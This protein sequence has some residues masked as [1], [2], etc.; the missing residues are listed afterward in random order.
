[1]LRIL[2]DVYGLAPATAAVDTSTAFNLTRAI[3]V[4]K[5]AVL[6]AVSEARGQALF[7]GTQLTA[8]T[9]LEEIADEKTIVDPDLRAYAKALKASASRGTFAGQ[10]KQ[11]CVFAK[12]PTKSPL[13]ARRSKFKS[14][15]TVMG[16][17]EDAFV[18]QVMQVS[19]GGGVD[20]PKL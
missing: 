18:K 12:V 9:F 20:G 4:I 15:N 16:A 3:P 1:V 2:R 10:P 19:F 7:L 11:M 5:L 17:P 6:A 14:K 13:L 8:A